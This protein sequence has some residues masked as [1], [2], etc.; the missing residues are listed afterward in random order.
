VTQDAVFFN[1]Y[2]S[3]WITMNKAEALFS[4]QDKEVL[5]EAVRKAEERTSGEIV[6]FVAGRSDSYPEAALR[7]GLLFAIIS[8]FTFSLL[9]IGTNIWLPFGIPEITMITVGCFTLGAALAAFIP[10][11]KRLFIP[12]GIMQQRVDEHAAMAFLDEEVFNTRERTGIL[13]F[14]SLFEHRVRV[15][16][17]SGINEKVRQEEWDDVV[18]LVLQG[19]KEKQPANGL[20]KAI[21]RCGELLEKHGVEIRPDDT[22]ELD[23]AVRFGS[24]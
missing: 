8:L 9:A 21:H 6:P 18:K 16:G 15:L 3:F 7:A 17:D 5:A 4:Q 11:I 19:M 14:I 23:N 10:G 1:V 12:A 24:R 22:N 20:L 13:I 2:H